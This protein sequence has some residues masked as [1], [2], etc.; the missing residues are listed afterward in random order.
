MA[1][2][3]QSTSLH[4]TSEMLIPETMHAFI[5]CDILVA[6]TY[7]YTM[8]VTYMYTVQCGMK[9]RLPIPF[10]QSADDTKRNCYNLI[11]DCGVSCG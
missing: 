5:F 11:A 1:M 6:Y 7:V 4:P 2:K 9:P 8:H 3:M 10:E